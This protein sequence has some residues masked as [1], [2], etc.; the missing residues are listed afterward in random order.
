ME[1]GTVGHRAAQVGAE[2]A[3]H[4]LGHL[5]AQNPAA[6]VKAHVVVVAERVALT[7][8]HKVVVT[9]Q[10]Q[11]DRPPHFA[12]RQRRPHGQVPSLRLF[13]A[14]APA[15]A[16]ADHAHRVQRN[17]QRMRHP[18]LH[19]AGVLGAAVDQPLP[20][21]LWQRIGDLPLQVKVLLPAHVQRATQNVR[22]RGQRLRRIAPPHMHGRQ[23]PVLL[24]H[25]FA[26]AQHCRQGLQVGTQQLRRVACAVV[27][28]GNHQPHDVAH[29]LHGFIRKDRFVVRKVRQQMV[30]R[31]IR[32][33]YQRMHPGRGPCSRCIHAAHPSMCQRREDGRGVQRARYFGQVVDVLRASVDMADCAFV[34]G[35]GVGACG[36]HASASS[37][38][39]AWPWVSS[40][41]RC[42][43]LPSTW[44]R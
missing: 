13:A 37:V 21:F 1:D 5:Q 41:K 28:V 25:G 7:G 27:P 17:I 23:N 38:T 42:S 16:A 40:Q 32:R 33:T 10:P 8:D 36:A 2:A 31:N 12:R 4:Q 24:C 3:V 44:R 9:V 30:T 20:V 19:F 18:V 11:L 15:H 39:R 6:A 26:H 34:V 35:Q 22:S 14:K 29:V 43:K